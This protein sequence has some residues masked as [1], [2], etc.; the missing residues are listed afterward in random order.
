VRAYQKV[1]NDYPQSDSVA[2]A[3]YKLGQAY[4]SLKQID[5]A[6]KAYETLTQKYPTIAE[7]ALAQNRLTTL[8]RQKEF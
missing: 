8:N 7:A 1:I 6:K 5:L 4:E 2:P 3:Y